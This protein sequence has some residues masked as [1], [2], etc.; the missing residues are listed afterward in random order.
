MPFFPVCAQDTYYECD[1]ASLYT[2][3]LVSVQQNIINWVLLAESITT[4]ISNSHV[5]LNLTSQ[6]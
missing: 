2:L 3:Y 4:I 6:Y 5:L 1:N